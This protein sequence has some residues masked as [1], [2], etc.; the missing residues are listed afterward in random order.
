MAGVRSPVLPCVA[1]KPCVRFNHNQIGSRT[2]FSAVMN[3]STLQHHR[4]ATG[5]PDGWVR[6]RSDTL[7]CRPIPHGPFTRLGV[8]VDAWPSAAGPLV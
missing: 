4:F 7:V 5:E 2:S 1:A 3:K 8:P 6:P